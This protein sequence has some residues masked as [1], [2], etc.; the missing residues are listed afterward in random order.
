MALAP[1]RFMEHLALDCSLSLREF[2][3]AIQQ[4]FELPAFAFDFENE[5][6]WG[7][8]AHAGIEYNVSRPYE[9]GTL[10]DCASRRP[11]ARVES[12]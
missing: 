3:H 12:G 2:C 6:E 9:R 8:V 11:P 7:L 5:T 10:T 1:I 4:Q